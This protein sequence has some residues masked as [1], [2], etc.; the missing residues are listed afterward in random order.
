MHATRLKKVA[1]LSNC[2]SALLR[3]QVSKLNTEANIWDAN[4]LGVPG[5][6][7]LHKYFS[8]HEEALMNK[9]VSNLQS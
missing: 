5:H 2:G 8:K 7:Q 1:T 9:V 3:M 6:N 4:C